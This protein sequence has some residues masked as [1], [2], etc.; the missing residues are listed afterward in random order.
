[1]ELNVQKETALV[2]LSKFN[3]IDPHMNNFF[4]DTF[5]CLVEKNVIKIEDIKI[6][7]VRAGRK[8]GQHFKLYTFQKQDTVQALSSGK[9]LHSYISITHMYGISTGP[10][11]IR[12]SS[13][14]LSTG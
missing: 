8:T 4:L 5:R 1:M 11:S 3:Y 14:L 9:P 13:F 6:G 12:H 7:S 10:T 2:A